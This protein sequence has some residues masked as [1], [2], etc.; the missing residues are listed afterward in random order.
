MENNQEARKRIQKGLLFNKRLLIAS[1]CIGTCALL[2]GT[3]TQRTSGMVFYFFLCFGI[4]G[5][6]I[7]RKETK[8]LKAELA[9][10]EKEN[11]KKNDSRTERPA[12]DVPQTIL[13]QPKDQAKHPSGF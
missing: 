9:D 3:F 7:A 13:E 5:I 6:F 12:F 11:E 2:Y 4:S 10:F 1:A 8:K